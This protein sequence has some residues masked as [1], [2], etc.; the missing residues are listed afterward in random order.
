MDKLKE[1]EKRLDRIKE[2]MDVTGMS[3][4]DLMAESAMVHV[5]CGRCPIKTACDQY[6]DDATIACTAVWAM[7]LRG[8]INKN[9]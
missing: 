3:M 8:E 5:D 9:A 4:E 2:L 1:L 6:T 7:Y